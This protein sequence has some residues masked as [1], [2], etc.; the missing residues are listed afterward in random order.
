MNWRIPISLVLVLLT[1]P[2]SLVVGEA[3]TPLTNGYT[4]IDEQRDTAYRYD[5]ST[6]QWTACT[7]R[8]ECFSNSGTWEPAF[9]GDGTTNTLFTQQVLNQ[10]SPL[11]NNPQQFTTGFTELAADGSIEFTEFDSGPEPAS[12]DGSP[13]NP[14]SPTADG[15]PC[16]AGDG[17][18]GTMVSG[19]CTSESRPSTGSSCGPILGAPCDGES[20]V[21]ED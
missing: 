21:A 18:T 20:C 11:N 9:G 1:V 6:G 4:I 16:T 17:T 12:A 7:N 2:I 3:A 5:G 14:P 15:Q 8:R 19:V 10:N 13:A